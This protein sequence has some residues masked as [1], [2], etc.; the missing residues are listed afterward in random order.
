MG[1]IVGAAVTP[2]PIVPEG[3]FVPEGRGG[4]QRIPRPDDW[5][6]GRSAPW[7]DLDDRGLPLERLV[8]A[9]EGREPSGI[10]GRP[11]GDERSSGVL[12]VLY[13][14][15]GDGAHVVLTRRASHLASHTHEVSFPGGRR[16]PGDTDLWA[17]AIREAAEE[18]DLDPSLPR[19]VG[20]L[21]PVV[22]VGSRSLIH[23]FVAVLTSPPDLTANPDE[24]EAVLRVP[25]AELLRDDVYREEEW[26]RHGDPWILTFFEL[27]GDTVW[28]ATSAMLR[29]LLVLGLGLDDPRNYRDEDA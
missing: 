16:D 12:V 17:T 29:Q 19:L 15:P 10:R 26:T 5:R 9:V 13:D 11:R 4:P 22:T 6:P 1:G 14:Q 7:A 20:C 27:V 28:G 3:P 2:A 25:V 24:V 23:P 21:D 8:A 18:V